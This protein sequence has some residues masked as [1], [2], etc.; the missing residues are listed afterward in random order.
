MDIVQ[1][2]LQKW[3]KTQ[4]EMKQNA[5]LIR[6]EIKDMLNQMPKGTAAVGALSTR[7]PAREWFRS[8]DTLYGGF[9]TGTKFLNTNVLSFLL[10]HGLRNSDTELLEKVFFTL[11]RMADSPT[12]YI[13]RKRLCKLPVD[14]PGDLAAQLDRPFPQPTRVNASVKVNQAPD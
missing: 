6:D 10:H 2:S 7:R 9:G 5:A 13:C 4:D 1:G 11:D 8:F 14:T 12:A 3:V